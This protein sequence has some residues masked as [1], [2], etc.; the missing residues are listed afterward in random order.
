MAIGGTI[1]NE[2]PT[3]ENFDL[4]EKVIKLL[5]EHK[6]DALRPHMFEENGLKFSYYLNQIAI[7]GRGETVSGPRNFLFCH[8]I[9]SAAY[10]DIKAG[11]PKG[12][13]FILCL[14]DAAVLEFYGSTDAPN[15]KISISDSVLTIDGYQHDLKTDE[16][17][18]YLR[19]IL[20]L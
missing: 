11:M 8:Y 10:Q 13:G 12:H 1:Q 15:E 9:R 16:G 20:P 7:I 17:L 6:S 3:L 2:Q 19:E 18:K 5:K 14:T 4:I